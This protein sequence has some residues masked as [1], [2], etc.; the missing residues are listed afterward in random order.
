MTATPTV[1]IDQLC[2]DM[3]EQQLKLF[4][5]K[6]LRKLAEKFGAKPPYVVRDENHSPI[7]CFAPVGLMPQVAKPEDGEFIR[8]AEERLA[9]SD[10]KF[11]TPE[12]FIANLERELHQE[13]RGQSR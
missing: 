9:D 5:S 13:K 2:E 4:A 12:E 8:V 7:A 10:R 11:L 6:S 3:T 1:D